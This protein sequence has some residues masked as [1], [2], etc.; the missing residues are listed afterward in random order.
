MGGVQVSAKAQWSSKLTVRWIDSLGG[1]RYSQAQIPDL[2]ANAIPRFRPRAQRFGSTLPDARG[3]SGKS[4]EIL[5]SWLAGAEARVDCGAF[6]ACSGLFRKHGLGA[7]NPGAGAG[8]DA[9][10]TAGLE[11]GATRKTTV[12]IFGCEPNDDGRLFAT[13]PSGSNLP[14]GP[15]EFSSPLGGPA[16]F[17]SP[18][19]RLRPRFF[20][21]DN[22]TSTHQRRTGGS[23]FL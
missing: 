2:V 17:S 13:A 20:K 5:M 14:G 16:G 23:Q 12:L 11:T 18:S 9:R 4:I 6:S 7:A 10:T 19:M 1:W 15:A 3:V 8:E 22:L 21:N